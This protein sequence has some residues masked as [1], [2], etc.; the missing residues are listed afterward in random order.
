[1]K[2]LV[3]FRND[4]RIADNTALAAAMA[5]GGGA[6]SLSGVFLIAMEQWKQHDW[7]LP[8]IDFILRNAL[9]L[10]QSLAAMNIPLHVI[11]AERFTDAPNA[12]LKIT[13][14]E[15]CSHLFFNKEYEVNEVSRDEAVTSELRAA[16]V[17]VSA[18]HDQTVL[19]P[20]QL[21]TGAGQFYRVFT[22][23]KNSWI[24][25]IKER[26]PLSTVRTIKAAAASPRES[27]HPS[28]DL[29]RHAIAK[30]NCPA[31][32]TAMWPAGESEAK[33]RLKRF[34]QQAI[35]TYKTARDFPALQGTSALSPY[36]SAGVISARKCL[37]AA[38]SEIGRASCRER[39]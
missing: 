22:P 16:G 9:A 37:N 27:K 5:Q 3:W 28:D 14:D 33:E 31:T 30:V 10:S 24:S 1:M 29:L 15:R 38:I 13:G 26:L 20:D 6:A 23:F 32:I 12:L 34:T 17:K 21:R 19:P 35:R 2:T 18:F 4:L 25:A 36:L 11:A 8:K 7:G 39:V